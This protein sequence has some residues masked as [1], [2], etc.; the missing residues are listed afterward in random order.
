MKKIYKGKVKLL[1][2]IKLNGH[3][4]G[5]VVKKVVQLIKE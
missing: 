4:K 2:E 1:I 3:E 5:D